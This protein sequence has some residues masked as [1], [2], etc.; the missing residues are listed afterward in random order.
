[1]KH[2]YVAPHRLGDKSCQRCGLPESDA[3]HEFVPPTI[4]Q[5]IRQ[6]VADACTLAVG[7]FPYDL[8][9]CRR[10]VARL[11]TEGRQ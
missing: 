6:E 8:D 4:P 7:R 5:K 2:Q 3:E 11:L 9:A 10:E 1:M